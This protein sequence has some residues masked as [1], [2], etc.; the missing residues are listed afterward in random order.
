MALIPMEY[1]G[2]GTILSDASTKAIGNAG[3]TSYTTQMLEAGHTYLVSTSF[4]FGVDVS[5]VMVQGRIVFKETT[6]VLA[7]VRNADGMK[8]GGGINM[9]AIITPT[10]NNYVYCMAYQNSGASQ[11][12]TYR[13]DIYKLS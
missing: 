6:N 5:N 4:Y 12:A 13:T 10:E 7:I 8:S 2:G 11:T 9:S 3:I 1:E